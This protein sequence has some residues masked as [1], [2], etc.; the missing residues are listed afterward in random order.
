MQRRIQAGRGPGVPLISRAN[1]GPKGRN[2]FLWRP[3]PRQPPPPPPPPT[4][5]PVPLSHG[6]DPPLKCTKP[7]RFL[8]YFTFY[9]PKWKISLSFHILQGMKFLLR[10]LAQHSAAML[11][12]CCDHWKQWR[13]NVATLCWAKSRRF[14]VSSS[15]QLLLPEFFTVILT[16]FLFSIVVVWFCFVLFELFSSYI[17]PAFC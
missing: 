2:K 3:L 8:N 17:V 13:N 1:W 10:F 16:L 14:L 5:H 7:K 9:K 15:N 4:H 6:L 11:E 12:Q